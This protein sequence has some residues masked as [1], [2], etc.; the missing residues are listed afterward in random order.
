MENV[1]FYNICHGLS[2][3]KYKARTHSRL[4]SSF[5]ACDDMKIAK[6][7]LGQYF[8]KEKLHNVSEKKTK[9]YFE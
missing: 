1:T 2:V 4:E 8:N 3:S 9:F 7:K 5:R 6:T